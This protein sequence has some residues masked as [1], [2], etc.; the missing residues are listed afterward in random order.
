MMVG[1]TGVASVDNHY[2]MYVISLNALCTTSKYV[3]YK[4][5]ETCYVSLSP[6]CDL[7]VV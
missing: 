3:S 7:H 5:R 1:D 2:H 6:S 4:L